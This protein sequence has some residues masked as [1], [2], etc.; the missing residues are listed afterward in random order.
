[1]SIIVDIKRV[2][3]NNIKNAKLNSDKLTVLTA[4]DYTS[5]KILSDAGIDMILVGDTLGMVIKGEENTLSVSIDEII[6]HTKAVVKGASR[7]F[8]IADM[9]F[10]SYQSS[11]DMAI[12][13]CIKVIKTSGADAVKLEGGLEIVELVKRL[14]SIGINVMSHIGL[15]PQKILTMGGYKIAGRDGILKHLEEALA[16]EKAGAFSIVLEGMLEPIAR[17]ITEK[18]HIP[19]IGIGASKYCDGQVL[20]FHDIFG[21]YS[22]ITPKFVRKY[23]DL[24]SEITSATK[25][26]IQDVKNG[27][28]PDDIHIYTK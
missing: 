19:T 6:Y 16:L 1:M 8:I 13:N 5:A 20:V 18:L 15:M 7:S 12:D 25:Q 4:Y 22:E 10:G 24:S 3:V 27:T 23:L 21:L 26:Y 14:S 2:T 9:P 28:F 11:I 17:E